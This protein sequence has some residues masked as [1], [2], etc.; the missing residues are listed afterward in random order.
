MMCVYAQLTSGLV[1]CVYVH[2]SLGLVMCVYAHLSGSA[3]DGRPFCVGE[4]RAQRTA[5]QT[6]GL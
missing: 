5:H 3:Q 2:L 4:G 6:C 1:V